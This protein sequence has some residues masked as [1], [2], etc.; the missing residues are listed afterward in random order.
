M[1]KKVRFKNFRCFSKE[2]IIDFTRTKYELLEETNTYNDIVKGAFFWGANASGKSSSLFSISILF[3]LLFKEINVV[4]SQCY[5]SKSKEMFFEYTFLEEK[6]EIV[7]YVAFDRE[8]MIKKESLK[9]NKDILLNRI[10]DSA[11]SKLTENDIFKKEDMNSQSVFLKTIYF[12]T[13][14]NSFPV[15]KKWYESLKEAVYISFDRIIENQNA[16]VNFNNNIKNDIYLDNYLS[17][18]GEKYINDYFDELGLPYRIKY[19]NKLS[20]VGG[21]PVPVEYKISFKRDGFDVDFPFVTE[22]IGNK[23]ILAILPSI[24]HAINNNSILMI[25]EFSGSFHNEL[26]NKTIKF[27]MKHSQSAQMFVVTHITSIQRSS[28]IRPD[29]IYTLDFGA[30]GA[31][32]NRAS[33][34]KPRETQNFEKMYLAGVF[35]GVPNYND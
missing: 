14:L 2:T 19:N 33:S 21:L 28:L 35:G 20:N 27:F 25:D 23:K 10:Y 24:L 29:Q 12:N 1:L 8:G 16:I 3:D 18:Y 22:S 15:L 7:Y 17:T 5:F 30:D 13:K 6:D 9:L 31:C 11:E 26:V 4:G 34:A 32:I